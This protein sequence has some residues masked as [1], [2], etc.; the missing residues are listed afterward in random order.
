MDRKRT[1]K[2]LAMAIV[3]IAL[4]GVL[5]ACSYSGSI[6]WT[7]DTETTLLLWV[8][9]SAEDWAVDPNRRDSEIQ[10]APGES[11]TET[12]SFSL[13]ERIA[14]GDDSDPDQ[15]SKGRVYYVVYGP[16]SAADTL[17]GENNI[18]AGTSAGENNEVLLSNWVNGYV[19]VFDPPDTAT[20]VALKWQDG[21]L[22]AASGNTDLLKIPAEFADVWSVPEP[23]HVHAYA[24][25]SFEL[26]YDDGGSVTKA[27]VRGEDEG[28]VAT[29]AY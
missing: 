24:P 15:Q 20:N 19:T 7:N 10:L 3:G 18:E 29:Y 2:R 23:Y 5:G 13:T 6:V 21:D 26:T 9:M 28:I 4:I 17:V 12:F 14:G 1:M 11:H 25:M 22:G 16:G 27:V 8:G